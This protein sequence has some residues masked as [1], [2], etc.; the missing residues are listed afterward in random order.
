M[1]IKSQNFNHSNSFEEY[2]AFVFDLQY[3]TPAIHQ[4]LLEMVVQANLLEFKEEIDGCLGA[5]FRCD[6]SLDCTHKDNKFMLL[7]VINYFNM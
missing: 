1:A 5:S 4:Q 7:K 6:A 2:D 3:V